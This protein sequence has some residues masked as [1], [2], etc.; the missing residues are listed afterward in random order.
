MKW[1]HSFLE[2]LRTLN[3]AKVR[4]LVAGGMAVNLHGVPRNTHDLDL[5]VS[6]EPAILEQAIRSL[7]AIGFRPRIPVTPEMVSD[8]IQR[9]RWIREKGM[10]VFSMV[11]P[12]DPFHPVD[13]FVRHRVPFRDAWRRRR[14]VPVE[15]T[16]V[17]LMSIR[18]LI[19]LKKAAGRRQDL[20]DIENLRS[21]EKERRRKKGRS[22]S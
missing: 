19:T 21:Y 4:Y 10:V 17:P 9:A 22:G 18:D 2:I 12:D 5:Y 6:L 11:D 13:I 16:G 15:G 14:I 20:S 1:K 7:M 3:D 8:P